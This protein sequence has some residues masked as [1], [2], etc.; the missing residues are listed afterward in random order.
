MKR[1]LIKGLIRTRFIF[2]RTEGVCAQIRKT[3]GIY[4]DL[5]QGV[6]PEVG[7][8]QNEV[9][10]LFGVDEDMRHWSFF[11]VLQHNVMVNRSMTSLVESLVRGEVPEGIDPKT[12]FIPD[13]SAG[14]EQVD[15][16]RDS[17]D[18]HIET[19]R[20]LGKLRGTVER[21]HPI[22]GMLDAH[23]WHCMFGLHLALH[24]KQAQLL[25]EKANRAGA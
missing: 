3:G 14:V 4:L 6:G 16:F 22:F 10:P 12:D 19:I 8:E 21:R 24:V 11:M 25:A 7:A 17:L 23:G 18:E 20:K 15:A 2:S 13:A 5:A 1:L 9:P